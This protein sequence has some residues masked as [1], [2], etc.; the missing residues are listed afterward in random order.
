[1]SSIML[2][3]SNRRAVMSISPM[4]RR[5]VCERAQS[6]S[7]SRPSVLQGCHQTII[8]ARQGNL[9]LCKITTACWSRSL[10]LLRLNKRQ[11]L[12]HLSS[13]G[14]QDE[15][16]EW[17]PPSHSPKNKAN[18]TNPSPSN[19][20]MSS[21]HDINMN[22][23]SITEIDADEIEVID[24]EATM[25][26]SSNQDFLKQFSSS[27][28]D[29]RAEETFGIESSDS[30]WGEVLRSLREEGEEDMLKQLVK[31]YGLEAE[32]AK[33][34]G[35]QNVD[36]DEEDDFDLD[37]E[38][39]LEGLS[40]DELID[41][42]IEGSASMSQLEMEILS[43]EADNGL[44]L[45][46]DEAVSQNPAY[47]EF[48]KM[49]LEDYY[50]KKGIKKQRV[51]RDT[52]Q[53]AAAPTTLDQY[54]AYPPDWKYYDSKA[55]FSRDFLEEDD[56]WIPPVKDFIPSKSK[57]AEDNETSGKS[58]DVGGEDDSGDTIDWLQARRSRLEGGPKR[59]SHMLTP[60][61]AETFRHEN[62]HIPVILHTLFTT[63]EISASLSAQGGTDIKVID[64]SDYDYGL[65]CDYLMIV[66][67]R[68]SSH[69]RVLAD[70]V[71]RNLK[72]RK[73][74]E[75]GVIGA[76][77]GAEGGEDIFSNKPS[78]NRASRIGQNLSAKVNDDWMVVDCANI[79]VHLLEPDTRKIINIEGLWDLSDPNSEGSKLRRINCSNEDAIDQ[80]VAENPVPEEY[81][82]RILL[83]NNSN[84][85][86][87]VD[88]GGRVH[89]VTADNF[90]RKSHSAKWSGVSRRSRKRR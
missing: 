24:L 60:E 5:A 32:L 17:I 86:N 56:S 8:S 18:N 6:T 90:N 69:I 20:Q 74:H 48:R 35:R 46:N 52:K 28:V 30:D 83:E 57:L 4:F 75:R 58:G 63:S 82:A 64:I 1:M 27:E 80:Y 41:E 21:Q 7:I 49:V 88:I 15:D 68:N 31:Q 70:S 79:H 33:L 50:E 36:I 44:D 40:D 78:R 14:G 87:W 85:N 16:N 2:A 43:E 67:G 71:V 72:E 39:S 77:K 25:N 84:R 10:T 26:N 54:S 62:S 66:S 13:K 19:Q 65:G 37:L 89:R 34:E 61:E 55:A 38:Q 3:K 59:P 23:T 81:A 53:D 9:S 47:I 29:A 12:R 42:L 45:D 11:I 76:M 73:L 22:L 51:P